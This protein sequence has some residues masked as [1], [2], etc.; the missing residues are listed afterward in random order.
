MTATGKNL[1]V[2]GGGTAGLLSGVI[3]CRLVP[4]S[5]I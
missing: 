3:F 1:V 2:A 5:S 4:I